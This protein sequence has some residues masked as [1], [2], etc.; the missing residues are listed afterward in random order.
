MFFEEETR[1]VEISTV[2]VYIKYG[3]IFAFTGGRKEEATVQKKQTMVKRLQPVNEVKKEA[4]VDEWKT[5]DKEFY[6]YQVLDR[7]EAI[8][9]KLKLLR[10]SFFGKPIQK[11]EIG[12]VRD[13]WIPYCYLQYHF[14]VERSVMFKKKGLEKEGEVALVFDMNEMHPFQY[15]YYESGELKLKRG[16]IDDGSRAIIKCTNSFHE[17][18]EKAI[19]YIQFKIMKRFYGRE[20]K[21]TLSERKRFF[22][23]AVELEIIYKGEHSNMR[24]AYLDEFAVESEHILGL[25]YRVENKF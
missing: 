21:L 18:E 11:F 19:D 12:R 16:K 9:S 7:Q 8:D 2:S 14:H 25:K 17:I 10:G 20:G 4:I 22:R 6:T 15:D 13:V 3:T 23:P 1:N 24:Y 5:K